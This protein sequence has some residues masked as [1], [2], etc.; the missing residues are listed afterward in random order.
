MPHILVYEHLSG[1]G[2]GPD[3]SAGDDDPAMLAMGV[4]MRD[5]I[6]GD[7]LRL[8]A[9]T[10]TC[11]VA[12]TPGAATAAVKPNGRL[13]QVSARPG[14]SACDFVARLSGAV[15]AAW[16]VAPESDGVLQQM[17]DAVREAGLRARHGAARW[18]GCS[19]P[20][21]ELTSS[22]R[23]TLEAL[24]QAGLRTP[25]A[26]DDCAQ[27]WVV[28]P[29]FGAG[30]SSTRVFRR[31]DD[32]RVDL[33]HRTATG[34]PQATLEP[35]V[36]GEPL[37][38][39]LLVGPNRVEAIA[40]NRQQI[41]IG[42]GRDAMLIAGDGSDAD[43]DGAVHYLGVDVNALGRAGDPRLPLLRQWATAVARAIPGLSGFIGIDLVWHPSAGPV[44]IEVNPRVTC[45][46]AGL[47][48]HLR[49]NLAGEV[50]RAHGLGA[51]P[52]LPEPMHSV[53]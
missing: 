3:N 19:R 7:L 12:A 18:I 13:S 1:G 49:R 24:A 11:A 53:L 25:L 36:E 9:T 21:I 48:A 10:L 22:K 6:V 15:D 33:Q 27:R 44:A 4:S 45:A 16:I 30:A 52:S 14:E 26:L 23:D 37:S 47:S 50:L 5:A 43:R 29:N 8:P 51:G 46:Y 28:K 20:A 35:F 32:A 38:V 31:L 2:A 39:S 34:A 40:F 42:H 41:A 17:H